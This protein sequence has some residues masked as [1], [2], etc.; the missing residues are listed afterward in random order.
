[1]EWNINNRIDILV[2]LH[3]TPNFNRNNL[4]VL[5]ECD[6]TRE[7]LNLNWLDKENCMVC[8]GTFE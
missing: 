4:S 1:M 5:T 8:E 6:I 7:A 3:S 2:S